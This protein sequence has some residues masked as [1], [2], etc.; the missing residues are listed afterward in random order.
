MTCVPLVSFQAGGIRLGTLVESL[1]GML[2]AIAVAFAFSWIM[3]F[4][5]LAFL[6]VIVLA[7][8]LH[9]NLSAGS[10]KRTNKA[11]KESTEVRVI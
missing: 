1:T 6:P 9:F 7:S 11:L 8:A 10:T 5:V 4:V 2:C 3:A